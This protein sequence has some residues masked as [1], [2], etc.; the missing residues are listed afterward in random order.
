[1]KNAI[2]GVKI[3]SRLEIRVGSVG[4]EFFLAFGRVARIITQTTGFWR[5]DC[6]RCGNNW[7]F[8]CSD[9]LGTLVVSTERYFSHGGF[10][11]SLLRQIPIANSC[12]VAFSA[13]AFPPISSFDNPGVHQDLSNDVL[14]TSLEELDLAPEVKSFSDSDE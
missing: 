4:C 5:L 11:R 2:I 14:L 12:E 3:G 8:F 10:Q 6:I 1:L 13:T 9:L 7:V